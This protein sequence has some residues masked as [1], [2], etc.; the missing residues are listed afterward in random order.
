[1]KIKTFLI[2][3]IFFQNIYSQEIF[4]SCRTYYDIHKKIRVGI[5]PE[6]SFLH[7]PIFTFER[8]LLRNTL[9][10]KTNK[11][12]KN[13][14]G[15]RLQTR[16][17]NNEHVFLNSNESFRLHADMSIRLF[18]NS[19]IKW[20]YRY[21]AQAFIS[22]S[23]VEYEARNRIKLEHKRKHGIQPYFGVETYTTMNFNAFNKAKFT[24]GI[25]HES[26]KKYAFNEYFIIEMRVRGGMPRLYYKMGF[27][28]QIK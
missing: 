26:N 25:E 2:C 9:T 27:G 5:E 13:E 14:I 1:M 7:N 10:V 18:S 17:K 8:L 12:I 4:I 23:E 20:T 3:F 21:R 16:S 6:I 11:I 28:I 22:K 24:I 15:Y 19:Q